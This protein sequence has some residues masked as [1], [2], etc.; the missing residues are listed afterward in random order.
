MPADLFRSSDRCISHHDGFV[1]TVRP[2][3]WWSTEL[4]SRR[5]CC[6]I[7]LHGEKIMP[8]LARLAPEGS[9]PR[10]Q[11]SSLRHDKVPEKDVPKTIP[12]PGP[13]LKTT[14]NK[15]LMVMPDLAEDCACRPQR[16]PIA[17]A[18]APDMGKRKF[19]M[20]LLAQ[21]LERIKPSATIA[22]TDKAR[23]LKA[24]GRDV[25]G[26]GAGEPDFDTP[27]HIK[28]A[29]IE[30]I[31]G[32]QDANTPPS[33]ASPSSRRRSRA[34]SSARTGSTTSRARSSSAPAASRCC[35]MPYGDAQSGRRGDH[36]GALLGELSG[37]RPARGRR[38]RWRCRPRSSTG[39]R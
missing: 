38:R 24:A 32:G 1:M 19:A 12:R 29:A 15:G 25:I 8:A 39:S 13:I 33:T 4:S 23:A 7:I 27:D 31:N 3:A 9:L 26:L 14:P 6:C 2:A 11:I 10:P 21:Q 36:P 18:S 17:E 35:S 37:H 5:R 22:V 28:E 20:G 16:G 34:S 30:A